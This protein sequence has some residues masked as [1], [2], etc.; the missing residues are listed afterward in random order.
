MQFVHSFKHRVIFVAGFFVSRLFAIVSVYLA[1]S[2]ATILVDYS[3]CN[4]LGAYFVDTF[5]TEPSKKYC[6]TIDHV[7]I[8]AFFRR[9]RVDASLST[10]RSCFHFDNKIHDKFAACSSIVC[11]GYLKLIWKFGNFPLIQKAYMSV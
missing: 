7:C 8:I 2:F 4:L 10:T 11:S 6:V 1:T 3:F 5:P 9:W